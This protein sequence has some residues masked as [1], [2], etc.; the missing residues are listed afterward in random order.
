MTINNTGLSE[1][2]QNIKGDFK[3]MKDISFIANLANLSA[4][5]FNSVP[6]INWAGT[7]LFDGN[8]LVLGPFQGRPACVRIPMGKGVCG[9]AAKERRCIRVANVHHFPGHIACDE[10][11]RSEIVIPLIV[12]GKLVGVFDVD[13]PIHDRFQ[14]VDET[15]LIALCD[16]LLN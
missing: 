2:Y 4:L 11:S 7:Y 12:D 15:N 13:S 9:T 6:E 14:D 3:A 5:I 1:T 8:E 10:R 16:L